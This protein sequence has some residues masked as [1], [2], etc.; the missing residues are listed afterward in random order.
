MS[1]KKQK[2]N[3]SDE[4]NRLYWLGYNDAFANKQKDRRYKR[5]ADYLDGYAEGQAERILVDE[6]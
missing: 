6:D 1:K 5:N 3:S 2:Q 4:S